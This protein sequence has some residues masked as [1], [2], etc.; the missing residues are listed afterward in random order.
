MIFESILFLCTVIALIFW[1]Y[2]LVTYDWNNFE[3]DEEAA[4]KDLF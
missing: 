3:E 2:S 4:K 1:V